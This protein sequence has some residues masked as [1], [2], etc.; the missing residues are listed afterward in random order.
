MLPHINSPNAGDVRLTGVRSALALALAAC[1]PSVMAPAEWPEQ[2]PATSCE[3]VETDVNPDHPDRRISRYDAVGRLVFAETRSNEGR[4]FERLHW[5]STRLVRVDSYHEQEYVVGNC[6]VIGGCDQPASRTRE[7][8]AYR[9]DSAGRLTAVDY[10]KRTYRQRGSNWVEH[11]GA[12]SERRYVYDGGKLVATEGGEQGDVTFA[13][14]N[15][16]PVRRRF[17]GRTSTYEWKDGRL[18]MYRWFDYAQSF[19]Y[20]SLRR[21]VREVQISKSQGANVPTTTAWTYD[22][23]GRVQSETYTTP[24]Q[25][26][27]TMWT[28]DDQGRVIS[29]SNDGQVTRTWEYAASCPAKLRGI[30]PPSAERRSLLDTCIVSPANGYDSCDVS[31]VTSAP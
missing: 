27:P 5:S 15:G 14:Q 2:P 8:S 6:D 20:D 18:V 22:A 16:H 7:Q 13:W 26:R 31:Y 12:E 11:D 30:R 1:A 4:G 25:S 23:A 17:N 28:Y 29:Q 9:Y 19:E 24:M 10:A 21:L 3:V